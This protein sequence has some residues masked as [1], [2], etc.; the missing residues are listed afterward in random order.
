VPLSSRNPD[1]CAW[2]LDLT[3][4]DLAWRLLRLCH[5]NA[6]LAHAAL[7]RA[8]KQ[9]KRPRGK[10]PAPDVG[11]LMLAAKYKQQTGCTKRKALLWASEQAKAALP[12]DEN[13]FRR[14]TEKVGR[15]SLEAF[16]RRLA[17]HG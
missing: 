10:P 9:A 3:P 1:L 4:D 6:E 5:G 7:S 17:V 8:I 12:S 2:V 15:S 11:W 14:L 13:T 16:V